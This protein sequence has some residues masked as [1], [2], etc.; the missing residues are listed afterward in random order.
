MYNVVFQLDQKWIPTITDSSRTFLVSLVR[1][2]D[3]YLPSKTETLS[4]VFL[5]LISQELL[6]GPLWLIS[7]ILSTT[8][9]LPHSAQKEPTLVR[10]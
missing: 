1:C 9:A 5:P 10:D 7:E 2:S 3:I 4:K 8:D 6:T